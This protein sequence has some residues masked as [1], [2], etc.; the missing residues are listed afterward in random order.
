MKL[1]HLFFSDKPDI[2]WDLCSQMGIKH[3]VAKLSPELTGKNPIWDFA[4]LK[5][6][7][8]KFASRGFELMALEGDQFDM[9]RIKL[10]LP[11]REQDAEHYR[12]MLHNMGELGINVLCYN[13]MQ[14]GWFRTDK[15][16]PERGGAL[17]TAFD[18]RDACGLPPKSR[19]PVQADRIWDNYRWFIS[20]VMP[21]AEEAGVKM[22]LHPDDPPVRTLEGIDRIFI[23]PESIDDALAVSD[24]P[25]HGLTFCQ[26]TYRTM[27]ADIPAIFHRWRDR[28]HFVHIRD[29]RGTAECFHE[30]FHDNGPTDMAAMLKMYK[31]EGFDGIIRS[32]HVPTMAGDGNDRPSYS[33]SGTLFGVGY[34]KG[35][36]DALNIDYK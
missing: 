26:G 20:E 13:F 34:L 9:T 21:S 30:T 8:E 28:V 32:D 24:S 4:T 31:D 2:S 17:V 11:G 10:G 29:V 1:S 35:M 12:M 3:A 6:A 19:V 7:K 15:N 22:C 5:E 18:M 33:M 25:S 27:G 14:T 36:M 16:Y 23:T